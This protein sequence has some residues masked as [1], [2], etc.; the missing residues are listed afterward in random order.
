[1]SFVPRR[2]EEQFKVAACIEGTGHPPKALNQA[3]Q[4]F[5]F[6]GL[7]RCLWVVTLKPGDWTETRGLDEN[8]HQRRAM[9]ENG[10]DGHVGRKSLE[11]M[12]C[13][14]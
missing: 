8:P 1:M 7:R 11:G 12:S 10:E 13:F 6:K 3:G 4:K 5:D 14:I 9:R 2:C